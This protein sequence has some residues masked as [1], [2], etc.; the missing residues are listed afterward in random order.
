MHSTLRVL[1]GVSSDYLTVLGCCG[2]EPMD[3]MDAV[4]VGRVYQVSGGAQANT[5]A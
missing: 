5:C 3:R 4:G 1:N 2:R